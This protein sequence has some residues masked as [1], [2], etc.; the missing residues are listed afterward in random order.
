MDRRI[1]A[2]G[3]VV[4]YAL[5]GAAV[6]LAARRRA[7]SDKV[8]WAMVAAFWLWTGVAYHLL[9]F[10][11]IN[12]AAY[13]FGAL[14]VVQ[15]LLLLMLGTIGPR[16]S[17][18]PARDV[19]SLLGAALI[20]YAAV[21]YPLLGLLVGHRAVELPWLGVTP[22]PTVIFTFGLLLWTAGRARFFISVIPLL[23]AVIGGSAAVL[24][25]VPQDYGLVAAGVIGVVFLLMNRRRPEPAQG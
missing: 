11:R 22:C 9:H 3:P 2:A 16:L 7:W 1:A 6:A 23:W 25:Q 24:L 12:R 20:A 8:A 4:A 21:V 18:Q 13:V 14:F 15:G 17:L 5:A 10:S 19:W